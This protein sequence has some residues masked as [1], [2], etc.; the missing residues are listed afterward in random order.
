MS[1][2][3]INGT[4]FENFLNVGLIQTTLNAPNAWAKGPPMSK[5]EEELARK[6]IQ[7]AL[8]SFKSDGN[9]ADIILLP[10][11]AAPRGMLNDIKYYARQLDAV[12][13]CG[14]DYRTVSTK[15]VAKKTIRTVSNEAH[16]FI[17]RHWRMH[18]RRSR[19]SSYRIGKTYAAH[20]EIRLLKSVGCEFQSDPNMYI[21]DAGELGKFA[22]LICFDLMDIHRASLYRGRI[23]HLFVLAY[24]RDQTSFGHLAEAVS[25][26]VFCNVVICNTGHHGGSL[27]VSPYRDPWHRTIYKHEGQGLFASQIVRLP[28]A[29][30]IAH[31]VLPSSARPNQLEFKAL[32]PGIE[33]AVKLLKNE[34]KI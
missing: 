5:W 32:P 1:T 7:K 33:K 20:E 4:L 22:V 8:L 31:K 6:E 21:F 12:I 19:V 27:A 9:C 18:K 29:S 11:L 10:E 23:D 17:P 3:D 34:L 13:I 30:L 2:T 16:L 15:T 28:V 14:L 26:S 25:R 24:N